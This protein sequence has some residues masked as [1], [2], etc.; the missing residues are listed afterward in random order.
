MANFKQFIANMNKRGRQL[1]EGVERIVKAAALEVDAAV[2]QGTPVDTGRARSN[3]IVQ[4]N[5]AAPGEVSSGSFDRSGQGAISQG[6]GAIAGF[7]VRKDRSIHITNNVPY[8][9]QL[10]DGSSAQAPANFVQAAVA[11]GAAAVRSSRIF[12]N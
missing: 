8:I 11:A 10:N 6:Q 12:N 2:V 3:W 5:A 1:E 7:K 4:I 9:G